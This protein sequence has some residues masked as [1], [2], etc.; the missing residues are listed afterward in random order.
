MVLSG[1]LN[2]P[3]EHNFNWVTSSFSSRYFLLLFLFF[4]FF[5]LFFFL[6]FGIIEA[7]PGL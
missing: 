5:Y 1:A 2:S 4:Y 7:S 6:P 3:L